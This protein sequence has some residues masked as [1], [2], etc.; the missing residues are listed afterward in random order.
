MSKFLPILEEICRAAGGVL[1]KHYGK[2]ESIDKKGD[3]NLVTVADRESEALIK[4]M[5]HAHFPTHQILGEETGADY[6]GKSDEFRW[7][8][9]PLDGT[10]NFAHSFPQFCVSIAL[11]QRGEVIAA[12]VYEPFYEEMYLACRGGGATLNGKPIGVSKVD[13]LAESLVVSGFP[14]FVRDRLDITLEWWRRFLDETHGMLRLG[15]AALDL[16]AVATG[17]LEVFWQEGLLP[18]DTAAG[19]LIVEEAGGRLTDFAGAQ[20]SPYDQQVLAS[21]GLVHNECIALLTEK[22][23]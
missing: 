21:N 1:M 10:T 18:W 15:A 22:S 23:D 17:R 6:D 8:V 11:E 3:V 20:F 12:G 5:I 19:W 16:C 2:L 7:V 14:Y 4:Q 13:T 9:D